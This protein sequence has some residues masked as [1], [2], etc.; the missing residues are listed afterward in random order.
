MTDALQRAI[1]TLRIDGDDLDPQEVTHLLGDKPRLG[2]QKGQRY[3]GH[4]GKE[5][6]A[7]TGMW[8]FGED[9]ETMPDIGSQIAALLGRLTND[10]AIWKSIASRFHCYICV[11]GHFHD[12]T[13]G[14]ALKPDVLTLMAER[15]LSIDFDLY[16]P[17][18]SA[19]GEG[20]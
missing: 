7:R 1:V 12:W 6:T 13:G 9:W 5:I 11:G 14:L 8:W 17:N 16:A 2:V 15:G 3:A 10:L 18:A 20:P 19:T 4:N